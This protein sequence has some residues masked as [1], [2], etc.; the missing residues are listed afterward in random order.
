ML[1]SREAKKIATGVK[2]TQLHLEVFPL[3]W[4]A[5]SRRKFGDHMDA[6]RIVTPRTDSRTAS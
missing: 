1:R 5:G 2:S 4:G 6:P 3:A